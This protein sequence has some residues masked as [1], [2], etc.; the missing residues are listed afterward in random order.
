MSK[1]CPRRVLFGW[2]GLRQQFNKAVDAIRLLLFAEVQTIKEIKALQQQVQALNERL[3]NI[4][5]DRVVDGMLDEMSEAWD[6][7]MEDI[8]SDDTTETDNET[9]SERNED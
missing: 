8:S 3:V 4:E 1:Q 6:E 9:E 5:I 7:M 2:F